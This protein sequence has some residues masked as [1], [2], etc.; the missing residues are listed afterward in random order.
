MAHKRS[1]VCEY[2]LSTDKYTWD[3]TE[4]DVTAE[5]PIKWGDS[6]LGARDVQCQL[7]T[8]TLRVQIKGEDKPLIDGKFPHPINVGDSQWYFETDT[9]KLCLELFKAR[10]ASQWWQSLVLGDEEIDVDLIEGSKYLDDSLL[11]K[12]KEAKKMRKEG[13][14]DAAAGSDAGPSQ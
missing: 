7:G 9:Q 5:I 4:T 13:G 6:K 11:R 8:T 10:G 3:Q 12:V 1:I 2:G 14:Q